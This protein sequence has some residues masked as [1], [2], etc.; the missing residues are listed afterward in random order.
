MDHHQPHWRPMPIPGNIC[1]ICSISHFPFCP[2]RPSFY[3]NPRFP[4]DP[5]SGPTG[6]P[7]PF[8]DG[9]GDLRPWH[10]NPSLDRGEPYGQFQSQSYGNWFTNEGD[11]NSK[12]PRVDDIHNQEKPGMVSSEDERRLKLIRDHGA[13]SSGLLPEGSAG[14]MPGMNHET[15]AYSQES[16]AFDGNYGRPGG[17]EYGKFDGFRDIKGEVGPLSVRNMEMSTTDPRFG[18]DDR[19]EQQHMQSN[20]NGF[21]NIEF[22]HSRYGQVDS[23]LHPFQTHGIK[24]VDQS[25][26][27]YPVSEVLHDKYRN[28]HNNQQWQSRDSMPAKK[29]QHSHMNNWQG[30]RMLYPEESSVPM[31]YRDPNNQLQQPYGMHCPVDR[32]H[33]FHS[34]G[35]P[36]D[37]R[38]PLEV[39][40]PSQDG[41]QGS[42]HHQPLPGFTQRGDP[43]ANEHGGYFPSASGGSENVGKMEASPFFSRQP[44]IPASIPPPPAVDPVLHISSVMKAYSSPPKTSCSLFPVPVGSSAV[45]PSSYP[46]IAEAHSMTLPY[47][48]NEPLMH[49]STGFFSEA[50]GDGQP[51][52][53]KQLSSDKPKVID[54]SHLF[55]PPHRASRPD[56]IVLIL[57][58]L[59]GSGK[60]Y[61]AKMLRDLEVENGGHAPRI[62]SMDDYFMTEVEKVENGDVLKS[63]IL[64]RGKK[65]ITK[66][67]MEYC[68]EPEMEESYRS[69]MLKAFKKTVE[70]GVF[71]FIIVDDRNLR[72]ADFAQ[73][74][75]IAKSSGYEVYILEATYKDPVG[76]A[77]RNVHGFTKDDIKK[78][79]RQWEEA[80]S[81]YLQLDVKSLF[82]GDDLKDGG[83]QEVDMDME[84]ED[85]DGNLS[86]LKEKPENNIAPVGEDAPDDLGPSKDGNRWDSEGD[87][88]SEV[89]ELGRSKWSNDADEDDTERTEG[90]KTSAL[91]G[92]IQAYGKKVKSVRWADQMGSTGFSIHAAKKANLLSLVIG[93]GTGYNLVSCRESNPIPEEEI[94]APTHNAVESKRQ[95]TFQE[96]LRAE[97][98]SFKVVFDRRRQ[99]IGG[100]GVEEE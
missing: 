38:R 21:Q 59:P 53:L 64:S 20:G 14:S 3:Q 17:G 86:E 50:V 48:H 10:R 31:D 68:Y 28:P 78:M 82:H 15:N 93:P 9:F 2:P 62:H 92:L 36:S 54:A 5:Y 73:F 41:K 75:A 83:I 8:T 43:N 63:S 18:S 65:P 80:P 66:K 76:C 23:S 13:V 16:S 24:N 96:R 99:R 51:F 33:D 79:A 34:P 25:R 98:E 35:L 70:E 60:S 26:L 12:R 42:L 91:S 85:F 90:V 30:T 61:L 29:P 44:P 95:S 6:P 1:P 56:H 52:S 39:G 81:L 11:R 77:A 19:R 88:L 94:P 71:T 57:R 47:F 89:K 74:W 46:P 40:F 27:P 84:D 72:V 4:F 69:S 100:L 49:S 58:G 22:P 37:V 67:V 55:K 97:Q 45:M 7:R 32:R 87:H